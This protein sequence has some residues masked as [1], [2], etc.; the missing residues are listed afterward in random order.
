METFLFSTNCE[1]QYFFSKQIFLLRSEAGKGL[2]LLPA[3]CRPIQPCCIYE[4]APYVCTF[5]YRSSET[6]NHYKEEV[7]L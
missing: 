6:I 3:T 4:L 1:F 5:T 7:D 2:N